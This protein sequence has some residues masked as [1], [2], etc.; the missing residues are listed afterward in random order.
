MRRALRDGEI[1]RGMP[2]RGN[3]LAVGADRLLR[4]G[5]REV[6]EQAGLALSAEA[7]T[8]SEGCAAARARPPTVAIVDLETVGGLLPHLAEL[9]AITRVLLLTPDEPPAHLAGAIAVGCRGCMPKAATAADLA[10]AV[11]IVAR[12]GLVLDALPAGPMIDAIMRL[13]AR[14]H[15]VDARMA[16]PLTAREVEIL[17]LLAAGRGNAEIA[18]RLFITEN[19]VKNH[20]ARILAKLGVKTRVDAAL[21]AAGKGLV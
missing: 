17:R 21:Y 7:A 6:A 11:G 20:L 8:V 10:G 18:E 15:A 1:V 13:L 16:H 12:G 3:V 2:D 4:A 5:L 9:A 14:T 19:T